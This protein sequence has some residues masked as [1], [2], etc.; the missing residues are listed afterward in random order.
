MGFKLAPLRFAIGIMEYWSNGIM[1]LK[2][3]LTFSNLVFLFYP[4]HSIIPSFSP[5]RRLYPPACKP[6]GLEAEP[7][8]IIAV[9][10]GYLSFT[11]NPKKP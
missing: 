1:G 11:H 5:R 7:E 9:W 6:Y 3:F 4:H 8:A 10:D 2:E